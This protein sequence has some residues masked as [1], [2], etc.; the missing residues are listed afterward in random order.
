MSDNITVTE[1]PVPTIE[2]TDG[3][4]NVTITQIPPSIVQLE[5]YAVLAE[6]TEQLY[7][8]EITSPGPQGPPGA[9]G[10]GGGVA[11]QNIDDLLDVTAPAPENTFVLQYETSEGLGGPTWLARSLADANILGHEE[12]QEILSNFSIAELSDVLFV[13]AP[14]QGQALLFDEIE[15]QW[16]PGDVEGGVG[17]GGEDTT[18]VH[19]QAVASAVWSITHNLNRWPSV[20]VVDSAGTVASGDVSYVSANQVTIVFSAAFAGKAY[21]N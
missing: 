8:V 3:I 20:E 21:L 5:E 7:I 18:Y 2:L 12:L 17:G 4:P 13:S 16:M 11:P 15:Q 6:I 9:P 1:E 10:G 14:T 19:N